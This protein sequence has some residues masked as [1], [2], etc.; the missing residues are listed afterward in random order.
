MAGRWCFRFYDRETSRGVV[1]SAESDISAVQNDVVQTMLLRSLCELGKGGKIQARNRCLSFMLL[2]KTDSLLIS[3]RSFELA[4]LK[5][6][7]FSRVCP[8]D[9]PIYSERKK[10]ENKQQ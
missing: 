7:P 6:T 4:V 1:F 3:A 5:H 10:D 8:P 2:E 9:I